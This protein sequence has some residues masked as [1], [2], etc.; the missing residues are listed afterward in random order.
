MQM[1]LRKYPSRFNHDDMFKD[2]VELLNF[3][4]ETDAKEAAAWIL[5]E[6]AEEI[7]KSA[8]QTFQRWTETFV[9]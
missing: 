9:N 5:G 2:L 3:A 6:Y 4:T 1:I 7:Y 8:I